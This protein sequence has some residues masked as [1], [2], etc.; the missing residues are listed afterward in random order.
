MQQLGEQLFAAREK[1][2]SSQ[3]VVIGYG[4]GTPTHDVDFE[5]G[6]IGVG[7]YY[8]SLFAGGTLVGRTFATSPECWTFFKSGFAVSL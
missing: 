3:R 7:R 6:C 1:P 8:D 4:S 2:D 5:A